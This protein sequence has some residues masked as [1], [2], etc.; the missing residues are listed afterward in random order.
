[1]KIKKKIGIVDLI[2]FFLLSLLI[3]DLSWVYYKLFFGFLS[4]LSFFFQKLTYKR[5]RKASVNKIFDLFFFCVFKKS[6]EK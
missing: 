6:N 3:S 4:K 1:M 2:D 5:I